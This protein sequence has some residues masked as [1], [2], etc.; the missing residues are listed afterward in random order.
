MYIVSIGVDIFDNDVKA[1]LNLVREIDRELRELRKINIISRVSNITGDDIVITSLVPNKEKIEEN[2]KRVFKILYNHAES[3]DDLNGV[4]QAKEK[5]GEGISYAVAKAYSKY[6]DAIVVAFDTY[7]GEGI[8]NE[9][10][11]FVKEIGEKFGYSVGSSVETRYI[12][13]LGYVGEETD[14]PI[15][16]ITVKKLEEI[17]RLA[18]LIYGALLSFENLR[19]VRN[20]SEINIVPPGVICTMTAFLNGNIID[21]YQGLKN[22][23]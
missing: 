22:V 1:N 5:A 16:V 21:L 19:F 20:G 9:M 23:D 17:K 6:G 8:V 14:D 13:G 2:N 11:S 3:F 12:D 18:Y 15:V 7:G 4:S 10:A